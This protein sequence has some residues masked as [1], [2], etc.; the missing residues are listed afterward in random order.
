MK[1]FILLASFFLLQPALFSQSTTIDS[2]ESQLKKMS[3]DTSKV[4][5]LNEMILKY[6]RVNPERAMELAKQSVDLAMRIR[7][8]FGLG[9]AYR[10]TG[11]LY[12]DKSNF[13]TASVY[14][15]KSLALFADKNDSR[16]RR[17]KGMLQ[18]NF[19]VIHHYK[20]QYDSAM[21]FYQEAA[22][23][24]KELNDD[25]LLF[26]TYNNLS[27]LYTQILDNTNA[28]KYAK[29]CAEISNRLKDPFKI[30]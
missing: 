18:H 22:K 2:L 20:G 23:L 28:L 26:L 30:S 19:G 3:A 10:L 29:E 6:Q 8:D 1:S 14:Y 27:T 12:M 4:I 25:G 15:N 7:F 9:S 16:S 24:Y 21:N 5:L 17:Y 11:I 13:D